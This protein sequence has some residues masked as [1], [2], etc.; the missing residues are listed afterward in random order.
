[1]AADDI[2]ELLGDNISTRTAGFLA[3]CRCKLAYDLAEIELVIACYQLPELE[4]TTPE[5]RIL[6][7]SWVKESYGKIH[8]YVERVLGGLL[9]FPGLALT[10]MVEHYWGLVRRMKAMAETTEVMRHYYKAV[11]QG[12][13]FADEKGIKEEP[14][15]E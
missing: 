1:M 2:R 10:E 14:M 11:I 8:E 12:T 7:D 6:R 5:L 13:I 4:L 9:E 3:Y 15:A